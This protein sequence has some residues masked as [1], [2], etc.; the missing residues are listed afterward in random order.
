MFTVL[1][2]ALLAAWFLYRDSQQEV[3]AAYEKATLL[4]SGTVRTLDWELAS[5]R[6]L[7][8]AV[9]N[10]EPV[11]ALASAPCDPVFSESR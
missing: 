3:A 6:K 5:A 10:R 7:M 11:R 1:P 8:Q 4:A 2:S 9:S